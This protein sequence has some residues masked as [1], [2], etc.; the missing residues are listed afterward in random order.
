M[1]E[2]KTS[3][4]LKYFLFLDASRSVAIHATPPTTPEP[5]SLRQSSLENVLD[6]KV[7]D[8]S[9]RRSSMLNEMKKNHNGVLYLKHKR[10]FGQ[11]SVKSLS[12]MTQSSD[13]HS[14]QFSVK[15]CVLT[16]VDFSYFNDKYSLAIPKEQISLHSLLSLTRH[17]DTER[18]EDGEKEFYCFDIAFSTSPVKRGSYSKSTNYMVRTFGATSVQDRDTWVDRIC[19]SISANLATFT[20]ANYTTNSR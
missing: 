20:M 13:S 10:N 16:N 4:L 5:S 8:P 17:I 11:V 12:H 19:Q 14:S 18:D 3:I 7:I 1:V 15:W 6:S 9:K 2:Y